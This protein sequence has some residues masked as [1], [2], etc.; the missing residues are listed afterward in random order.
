MSKEHLH[1]LL[2]ELH[3]EL[4]STDSVDADN[5]PLL[6]ELASE[7][8]E[9]LDRAAG[10]E[11]EDEESLPERLL[12]VGRDFE[13]SHPRLVSLIGRVADALSKIGV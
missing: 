10:E 9:L 6:A 3:K 7:I 4:E 5:R 2:E 1:E 8:R 12:D 13:D 11:P